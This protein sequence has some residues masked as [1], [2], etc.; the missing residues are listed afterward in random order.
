MYQKIAAARI[1]VTVQRKEAERQMIIVSA[2]KVLVVIAARYDNGPGCLR[3]GL[4]D[5]TT[6]FTSKPCASEFTVDRGEGLIPALHRM[7]LAG[8]GAEKIIQCELKKLN[9]AGCR[10]LGDLKDRVADYLKPTRL[11]FV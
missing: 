7:A 6:H 10:S 4:P 8:R 3:N 11:R 1:G 5:P 9:N 2:M